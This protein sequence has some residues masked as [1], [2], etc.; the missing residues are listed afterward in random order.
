MDLSYNSFT[1]K[2]VESIAPFVEASA[3]LTELNLSNNDGL[4]DLGL[5]VRV[6]VT[7]V[8]YSTVDTLIHCHMHITVDTLVHWYREVARGSE[9]SETFPH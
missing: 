3:S 9:R 2:G 7:V 1:D 5:Q 6:G 8:C 4:G